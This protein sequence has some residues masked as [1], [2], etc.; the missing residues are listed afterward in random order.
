VKCPRAKILRDRVSQCL[1]PGSEF[2]LTRSDLYCLWH[3][4]YTHTDVGELNIEGMGFSGE[5]LWEDFV[6][7]CHPI[8]Q[9]LRRQDVGNPS[10]TAWCRGMPGQ[11]DD[12]LSF[13][14]NSRTSYSNQGFVF[15]RPTPPAISAARVG[16]SG[17]SSITSLTMNTEKKTRRSAEK[18]CVVEAGQ[19]DRR[20][21]VSMKRLRPVVMP[22][23]SGK[24]QRLS[25]QIGMFE[26]ET[27]YDVMRRATCNI[28]VGTPNLG[29]DSM[30]GSPSTIP[31]TTNLNSPTKTRTVLNFNSPSE[32]SKSLESCA[33]SGGTGGC[34]H[35]MGTMDIESSILVRGGTRR[36]HISSLG[37]GIDDIL[38]KQMHHAHTFPNCDGCYQLSHEHLHNSAQGIFIAKLNCN[39]DMPPVEMHTHHQRSLCTL[40]GKIIST[41]L[42]TEVLTCM[43]TGGSNQNRNWHAAGLGQPVM[44]AETFARHENQWYQVCESVLEQEYTKTLLMEAAHAMKKGHFVSDRA[45]HMQLGIT[46]K[47]DGVFGKRSISS[48]KMD[49]L[50]GAVFMF[51]S[52]TDEPVGHECKMR[53]SS[54]E[55]KGKC[56]PCDCAGDCVDHLNHYLPDPCQHKGSAGSA[57]PKAAG[58]IFNRIHALGEAIVPCAGCY[59]QDRFIRSKLV[60]TNPDHSHSSPW[61]CV[62]IHEFVGDGDSTVTSAINTM[63]KHCHVV[64]IPC[65]NHLIKN[66]GDLLLVF[67]SFFVFPALNLKICMDLR[68]SVW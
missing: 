1:P 48:Q 68:S 33:R 45:G 52:V 3:N 29:R 11:N 21:R 6:T 35:T 28:P 8:L 20:G 42:P 16:G 36:I 49:S 65:S 12:H 27:A 15:D 66:Q 24:A 19:D 37:V 53:Y 7:C 50:G 9:V 14:C 43:A 2:M 4:K 67:N 60:C 13:K 26:H 22:P 23:N 40:T 34:G 10:C 63:Y 58:A 47:I 18:L 31:R 61:T 57:E 46:V 32:T 17:A 64:R 55:R 59:S 30:F 54:M 56:V 39:C 41:A 51:G 44:D 38:Q 62:L 25:H 5:H